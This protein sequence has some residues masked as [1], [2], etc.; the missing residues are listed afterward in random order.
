MIRAIAVGLFLFMSTSLHAAPAEK[1]WKSL[2]NGKSLSPW[3]KT[4][5]AGGGEVRLDKKFKAPAAREPQPA[6]KEGPAIVVEAGASTSST[7]ATTAVSTGQTTTSATFHA[8]TSG[9]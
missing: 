1:G 7:S 4:E 2:F 3:T 8:T 5:F 9:G 6:D